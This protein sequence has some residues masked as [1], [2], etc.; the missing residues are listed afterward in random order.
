MDD[1]NIIMI[2][3]LSQRVSRGWQQHS[4]IRRWEYWNSKSPLVALQNSVGMWTTAFCRFTNRSRIRRLLFNIFCFINVFIHVCFACQYWVVVISVEVNSV[5]N[6]V[7]FLAI[8]DSQ[9]KIINEYMYHSRVEVC[10]TNG[11]Y[12]LITEALVNQ[13]MPFKTCL[14]NIFKRNPQDDLEAKL[15]I[16]FD[17]WEPMTDECYEVSENI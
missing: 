10:L 9:D 2:I 5:T 13:K 11:N 1:I 15:D 16:I 7:D 8:R 6:Y 3:E 17:G 14:D 12:S 4:E